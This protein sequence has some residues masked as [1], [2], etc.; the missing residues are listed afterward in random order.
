MSTLNV[1][2]IQ[3]SAAAFEHARLVQVVNTTNVAMTTGTTAM[4]HDNT[5]PQN[6]EGDEI[7]SRTITPTN[8][9][10]ILLFEVIVQWATAS[11][12]AMCCA[13]FKDSDAGAICASADYGSN[14]EQSSMRL[15]HFTT[16]S[17][18]TS[19]IEFTVRFGGTSGTT[20]INGDNGARTYG[21]VC[22]TGITISEIRV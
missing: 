22:T 2:T 4:P 18:G 14:R 3:D 13:L 21:G 8:T 17:L 19:E 11:N 16:G 12:V 15:Q 20:T 10:N 5:I 6:D 9:N 7:L 1:T